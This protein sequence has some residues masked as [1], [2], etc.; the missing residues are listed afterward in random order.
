MTGSTGLRERKRARTRQ[1]IVDAALRLFDERGFEHTTIAD[2]AAAADIAP[3][4]FFGYF[5]SKEDVV[6]YDF[7][8][9]LDALAVALAERPPGD[10]GD[11]HDARLRHPGARRPRLRRRERALSGAARSTTSPRSPPATARSWAASRTC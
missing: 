8:G 3:R 2:I 5:A 1:A 6:F 7:E 10:D 4:T 9:F 11:R